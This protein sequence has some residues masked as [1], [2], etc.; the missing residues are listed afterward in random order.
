MHWPTGCTFSRMTLKG[1]KPQEP[2]RFLQT[3]VSAGGEVDS[4]ASSGASAG[5]SL[6]EGASGSGGDGR[7]RVPLGG[8]C[9]GGGGGRGGGDGGG[10]ARTGGCGWKPLQ[11]FCLPHST[12]ASTI[13]SACF[14]NA[15][16]AVVSR[17]ARCRRTT[18]HR[19]PLAA[20]PA[21]LRCRVWRC[22]VSRQ[23]AHLAGVRKGVEHAYGRA[24]K[25]LAR[26]ASIRIAGVRERDVELAARGEI[27]QRRE[28]EYVRRFGVAQGK[29]AP[30][31]FDLLV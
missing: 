23:A 2:P 17:K 18:P 27:V 28:L 31:C 10:S 20:E 15:S 25:V 13:S 14:Q 8:S 24:A 22:S 5:G 4:L 6:F 12:Y 1:T 9:G 19:T 7:E 11:L 30:I 26:H 29:D 16:P 21:Q 3:A